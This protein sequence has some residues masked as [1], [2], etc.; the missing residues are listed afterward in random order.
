MIVGDDDDTRKLFLLGIGNPRLTHFTHVAHDFTRKILTLT[1]FS[2]GENH[3]TESDSV[4]PKGYLLT[5]WLQLALAYRHLHSVADVIPHRH[6]CLYC[7]GVTVAGWLVV[8]RQVGPRRTGAI[9]TLSINLLS[10]SRHKEKSMLQ[11]KIAGCL[12]FI[13][14]VAALGFG[15]STWLIALWGM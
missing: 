2:K 12:L 4:N 14:I 9:S 3:V 11:V 15:V 8:R 10:W 7:S 6:V 1:T 13:L 5:T